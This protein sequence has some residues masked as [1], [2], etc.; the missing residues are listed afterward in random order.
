MKNYLYKVTYD[1]TAYNRHAFEPFS[2]Q[3]R[4]ESWICV[5]SLNF[6]NLL[7][8]QAAIDNPI[9]SGGVEYYYQVDPSVT[10]LA[11]QNI[12]DPMQGQNMD[13]YKDPTGV[14][15]EETQTEKNQGE[16]IRYINNTSTVGP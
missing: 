10:T 7:L 8:L 12:A 6:C 11:L 5:K 16:Q 14:A 9:D 15:L 13:R 1:I 4:S 2:I 3:G